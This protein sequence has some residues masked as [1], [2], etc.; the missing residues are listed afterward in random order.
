M[1]AITKNDVWLGL[2]FWVALVAL[3]AMTLSLRADEPSVLTELD[4]LKADNHLLRVQL[5]QCGATV[6]DRETRLASATL[7]ADQTR[8]EAEFRARLKPVA[9]AIFNWTTKQFDAPVSQEKP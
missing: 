6:A 9:G 2:L 8:L 5:A 3:V 4:V 1:L 7:S